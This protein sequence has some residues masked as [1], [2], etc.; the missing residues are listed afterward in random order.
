MNLYEVILVFSILLIFIGPKKLINYS[1]KISSKVKRILKE[2]NQPNITD[3]DKNDINKFSEI[4]NSK[5]PSEKIINA[6]EVQEIEV[7]PKEEDP[8]KI[9][10]PEIQEKEASNEEEDPEK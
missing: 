8:E 9:E 1:E 4:D 10:A 6:S 5:T 7:S 3:S 2:K